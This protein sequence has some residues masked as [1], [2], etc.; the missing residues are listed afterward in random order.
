MKF[1]SK[2]LAMLLAIALVVCLV[3][4]AFADGPA[5]GSE[6]NPEL[7]TNGGWG[8]EMNHVMAEGETTYWFGFAADAVGLLN[9]Q[10]T[11]YEGDPADITV[12]A[13]NDYDGSF[14]V[15]TNQNSAAPFTVWEE[16]PIL[17]GIS[18]PV[19]SDVVV[20]A[21]VNPEETTPGYVP[22][23][24]YFADMNDYTFVAP[25]NPNA[26]VTYKT[27]MGMG[28]A[29]WSGKGVIIECVVEN[30]MLDVDAIPD[31]VVTIE[32]PE[33]L[34]EYTDVMDDGDI[35]FTLP[36]TMMGSPMISISNNSMSYAAATY[37]VS[38]VDDAQSECAH[39]EAQLTLVEAQE[40]GCHTPAIIKHNECEC[41]AL[42]D[43]EGNPVNYADVYDFSECANTMVGTYGLHLNDGPDATCTQPGIVDFYDCQWCGGFYLD[44]DGYEP[45]TDFNIPATKHQANLKHFE[46][47]EG[48]CSEYANIEYWECWDCY[49]MFLDAD[50]TQEADY[51]DVFAD[52]LDYTNHKWIVDTSVGENFD[53]V[54]QEHSCT[55]EGKI[56]YKCDLGCVDDEGH[57]Y[58]DEGYEEE[59]IVTKIVV[60]PAH[61]LTHNELIP[62]TK[63]DEGVKEHWYCE[64]CEKF[65]A[66][67]KATKELTAAELV[68]AKLEVNDEG[69][70]LPPSDN[71]NTGDSGMLF[72][73]MAAVVS[74][75]GV[76]VLSKKKFF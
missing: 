70:V 7:V 16:D 19:G 15:I 55:Q 69:E 68:I 39:D 31:T 22:V 74:L 17:I 4:A 67:A 6:D 49:K 60:T 73:A 48:N 40:A 75:A 62:A 20:T 58:T 50:C 52:E 32:T 45:V 41:G 23:A 72:V 54:L 3:P 10:I 9:L 51:E 56:Q 76:M 25:I 44:V 66:D 37:K 30:P 71:P 26:T 11:V 46:A 5:L 28:M 29:N 21:V 27:P 65:F 63:D 8:F 64:D 42:F 35:K 59:P 14:Q 2:L 18:G 53:G 47:F 12:E 33:G 43:L 57:K 61:N 1:T 34:V 13:V 24:G 38:I 36:T